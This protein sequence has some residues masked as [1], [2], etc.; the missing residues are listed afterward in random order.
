MYGYSKATRGS[1]L[2]FTLTQKLRILFEFII[3]IGAR[4]IYA[5]ILRK[6][7]ERV[8]HGGTRGPTSIY[9]YKIS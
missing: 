4:F 1:P 5:L 8:A 7:R 6:Y 3:V 2:L 9:V